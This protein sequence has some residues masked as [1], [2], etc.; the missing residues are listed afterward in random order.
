EEQAKVMMERFADKVTPNGP[1]MSD[2]VHALIWARIGEDEKAYTTWRKSWMEFTD[3]PLMLFSEKR[4]KAVTYFT[5]GA[6]GCLQTVIYG[7]L[8]FR[9]DSG[10]VP[11]PQWEKELHGGRWLTVKPNLPKSW[12]KV[13]LK[14]FTVLGQR[15]TLTATHDRVDVTQGEP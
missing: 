11:D 8:G 6:A 5:T 9:I 3:H 14:N 10:Q 13:T 12:K 2:S 7:F 15:Y 4:R 1:A